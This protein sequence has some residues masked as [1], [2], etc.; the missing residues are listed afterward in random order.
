MIDALLNKFWILELLLMGAA[1]FWLAWNI[2]APKDDRHWNKIKNHMKKLL[3]ILAIS[4]SLLTARAQDTSNPPPPIIS[5]PVTS[6]IQ[7]LGTGSNWMVAPY[8]I[9]SE[10]GLN[11][12]ATMGGGIGFGYKINDFVVPT[13]RLDYLDGQLWMPSGSLQLQAPIVLFGKKDVAGAPIEGSGLTLIPF[14]FGGIATP[15]AGKGVD[16]G[17]AVGIYGLGVAVRLDALGGIGKKMDFILDWEHW[18]G[19]EKAQFR[20]GFVYKF[21]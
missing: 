15:I 12:K 11:H 4:L 16:N 18:T 13:M 3:P 9:Y 5:G 10:A 1:G 19:F 14:G 6:I 20:A 8:G 2:R 17:T 7:F 21:W